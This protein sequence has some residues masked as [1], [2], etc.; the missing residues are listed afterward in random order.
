MDAAANPAGTAFQAIPYPVRAFGNLKNAR[1]RIYTSPHEYMTVEAETASD[2]L[3]MTKITEPH[4]IVRDIPGREVLLDRKRV[5]DGCTAEGIADAG[6][7]VAPPEAQEDA[8]E[9]PPAAN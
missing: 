6:T 2:A 9:A 7:A 5:F 4:R 3:R 8:A 1:Y